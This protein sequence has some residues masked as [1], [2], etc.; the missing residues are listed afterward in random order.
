MARKMRLS[1]DE[2]ALVKGYREGLAANGEKEKEEE[3]DMKKGFKVVGIASA[4]IA[5]V[6]GLA[7][8]AYRIF[9]E[10]PAGLSDFDDSFEADQIDEDRESSEDSS[11]ESE[12]SDNN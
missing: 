6:S 10:D 9:F 4:A 11:A 1:E 7:Y 3:M 8:G 12:S 2:V 5:A